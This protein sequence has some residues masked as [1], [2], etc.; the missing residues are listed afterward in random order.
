M[1]N[2]GTSLLSAADRNNNFN[3][4]AFGQF[5]AREP[6]AWHD[7]AI[8]FHCDSFAFES[9][10]PDQIYDPGRRIELS[11]IAIDAECNH[12]ITCSN[13]LGSSMLS[14]KYL[15]CRMSAVTHNFTTDRV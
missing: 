3:A 1:S 2:G 15:Y 5:D 7:F 12:V 4:V 9:E 10:A 6:A 14:S 8:A 13:L 11:G